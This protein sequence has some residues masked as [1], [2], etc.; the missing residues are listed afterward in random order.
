MPEGC[1]CSVAEDVSGP[2]VEL[3]FDGAQVCDTVDGE[4]GSLREVAA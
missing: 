3:V 1:W 2:V 4:G